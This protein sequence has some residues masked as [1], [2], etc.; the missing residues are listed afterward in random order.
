MK[1]KRSRICLMLGI[2]LIMMLGLSLVVSAHSNY[3][4]T[5]PHPANG[6]TG[7]ALHPSLPINCTLTC[8]TGLN[9]TAL[10]WY[11]IGLTGTVVKAEAS[12]EAWRNNTMN[13]NINVSLYSTTYY[14]GFNVTN[15]TTGAGTWTN[16]TFYFTSI[17][18]P[19][20]AG[21]STT[22]IVL[23]VAPVLA[24]MVFLVILIGMMWTG[25]LTP[26]SL[27]FVLVIAIIAVIAISIMV[28]VI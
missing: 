25:T 20:L 8:P 18:D 10:A 27:I 14:W 5:D 9:V 3:L 6:A 16:Q 24:A 12:P 7:V 11:K 2:S 17:S 19:A 15:T 23:S 22:D 21:S 28:E 4:I 26:E 13:W 1:N